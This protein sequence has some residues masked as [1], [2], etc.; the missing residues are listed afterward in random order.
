MDD[1]SHGP[2]HA[3]DTGGWPGLRISKGVDTGA[4]RED[5]TFGY[6]DEVKKEEGVPQ[7]R[8]GDMNLGLGFDSL[9]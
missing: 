3:V 7:V 4:R 8:S 9:G 1:D 2:T 6:T 5:T